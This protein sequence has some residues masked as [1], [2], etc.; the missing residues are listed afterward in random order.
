MA[1]GSRKGV[2]IGIATRTRRGTSRWFVLRHLF[3][4]GRSLIPR[5]AP[6]GG[7]S[8][9]RA[10]AGRLERRPRLLEG[11]ASR[12]CPRRPS[13]ASGPA[14]TSRLRPDHPAGPSPAAT[15]PSTSRS[16]RSAAPPVATSQP[17][18]ARSLMSVWRRIRMQSVAGVANRFDRARSKP[19]T[20]GSTPASP[21]AAIRGR[22]AGWTQPARYASRGPAMSE[23]AVTCTSRCSGKPRAA[24]LPQTSIASALH[25]P[26][27]A[28]GSATSRAPPAPRHR[29]PSL[30]TG[31]RRSS[32]AA[33]RYGCPARVGAA[34]RGCRDRRPRRRR[35]R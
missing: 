27:R 35:W 9:G 22:G 28:S 16:S 19:S 10:A 11:A 5:D 33:T 17:R 14:T 15:R 25:G 7:R 1:K 13:S 31:R 6:P 20:A 30:A 3:A 2:G 4:A 26:A 29:G 12:T 21:P 18:W 8:H 32:P 24:G 23:Q 34:A